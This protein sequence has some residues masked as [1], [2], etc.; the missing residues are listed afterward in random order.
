MGTRKFA[1]PARDEEEERQLRKLAGSRT[2]PRW[3]GQR[4]QI[5]T[6][7]WDGAATEEIAEQ[8][9]LRP[10]TVRAWLNR[11][12]TDGVAGLADLPRSGRPQRLTQADRS[13]LVRLAATGGRSPWTL[14]TLTDAAR[15]QGIAVSRSQLR[16]VL[17]DAGVTWQEVHENACE[18]GVE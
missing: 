7:S 13:A 8:V 18:N 11:F 12:D 9:G 16:R 10:R 1:R 6:L 2:V 15:A 14:T 5:V 3:L 17:I 4:A